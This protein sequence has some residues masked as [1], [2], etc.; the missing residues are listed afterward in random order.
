MFMAA[1]AALLQYHTVLY[2]RDCLLY[3]NRLMCTRDSPLLL[4]LSNHY[5]G[6]SFYMLPNQ[7]LPYRLL[8]QIP[9]QPLCCFATLYCTVWLATNNSANRSTTLT[10]GFY[11]YFYCFKFY[12]WRTGIDGHSESRRFY[13]DMTSLVCLTAPP[14]STVHTWTEAARKEREKEGRPTKYFFIVHSTLAVQYYNSITTV[15]QYII[16][17]TLWIRLPY[18]T[19]YAVQY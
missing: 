6:K 16:N 1:T 11:F 8:Y 12:S 9:R 15:I 13:R 18:N 17:C 14:P 3:R 19:N 4:I 2:P 5:Y 7:T 10:P